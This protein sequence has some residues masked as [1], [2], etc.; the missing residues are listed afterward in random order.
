[1]FPH[2]KQLTSRTVRIGACA[3]VI[4]L[5]GT[6]RVHA[7]LTEEITDRMRKVSKL[8]ADDKL[9]DARGD[10]VYLSDKVDAKDRPNIDFYIALSYVYQYYQDSSQASL[11]EAKTRF[12]DF[13]S[14]YGDSLLAPLAQFNLA[15]IHAA[16][17]EYEAALKLY[18][19]LYQ[20]PPTGIEKSGLLRKITRIYVALKKWEPG[21]PYFQAT[22]QTA[23]DPTE[24]T[25][26]AAYLMIAQAKQGEI[27]NAKQLLDFFQSPSPVFYTPRFN[28][29]LMEIGDQ[30]YND[31]QLATA[32]LFY[33]L[34]RP[35]ETLETGL[36]NYIEALSAQLKRLGNSTTYRDLKIETEATLETARRDLDALRKSTN[37]TPLVSW[38]IARLYLEMNRKWEAYW[39]FR[40]LADEYPNH[41]QS[42]EILYSAFSLAKQLDEDGDCLELSNRYL[43][44]SRYKQFR[45]PVANQKAAIYIK[46]KEF[47]KL[48]AMTA[49]FLAQDADSEAA[50]QIVFKHAFTRLERLENK[51]MISELEGF[52]QKYGNT[53]IRDEL[54]YFLGLGYLLEQQYDKAITMFDSVLTQRTSP[55]VQDALFRKGLAVLSLDRLDEARNII[56]DF[57]AKYPENRLRPE[58]EIMVGDILNMQGDAAGALQRY[59]GIP[60]LTPDVNY[61]IKAGLKIADLLDQQRQ[62]TAAIERL[63]TL[64]NT[65]ANRV[66]A[67]PLYSKLVELY[68]QIDEP[69]EAHRVLHEALEQFYKETGSPSIGTLLVNYIKLDTSVRQTREVTRE[70][71][72]ELKQDP[73]LMTRLITKRADQYRFF[74]ENPAIDPIVRDSFVRDNEFRK[75]VLESPA[76]L[77]ALIAKTE[78]RNELI[79]QTPAREWLKQ[80]WQKAIDNKQVPLAVRIE[81]AL[82]V[83]AAPPVA[84]APQRL[85]LIDNQ[86]LWNQ[87]DPASQL[88][89]LRAIAEKNPAGA[90][91]AL[92]QMVIEYAN[93]EVEL[94]VHLLLA[95]LY[96]QL[97]QDEAAIE[98]YR[99]ITQRFASRRVAGRAAIEIAHLLI[100]TGKYD[101]AKQSLESVLQRPEWRGELHAEALLE[102][103][104][105]Y[106]SQG[107]YAEAH[108]FYERIILG[109]PSFKEIL[110]LAFYEDIKVLVAMNEMESARTVYEAY[111]ETPGLEGTEGAL[112]I[113]KEIQE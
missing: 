17:G 34:I 55:Y 64:K 29:A 82:A 99:V 83:S 100:K 5:C 1:M 28:S 18:I 59:E 37:Y 21:M 94:D 48:F 106:G 62:T 44:N 69:F 38:R 73:E 98:R 108:G 22:M 46:R 56:L 104:R 112:K 65:Y 63:S 32:G 30:L 111:K 66:E 25:T 39:R 10:L 36:S 42:E 8:I 58:A 80:E 61:R 89:I 70:F 96:Q 12:A 15:D 60:R 90:I 93:T 95:Q 87:L 9:I 27:A 86:E 110:A 31:G 33:Q 102:L 14:K 84:P 47:E 79:P 77:D 109:Y 54:E 76:A 43:N 20:T 19:P 3:L 88:W 78:A 71:W 68:K 72:K 53:R 101:E 75:K 26:A 4:L 2:L 6:S 113:E 13:I 81:T 35:Y 49:P 103:G 105:T 7:Q 52:R 24:R 50:E 92:E 85:A 40:T 16:L 45:G 91:P 51:K 11:M 41:P 57:I 67:I 23:D 74:Q 107:Q 97:N